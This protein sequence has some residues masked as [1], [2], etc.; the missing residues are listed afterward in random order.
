ME[1]SGRTHVA[2]YADANARVYP[3][4]LAEMQ[5]SLRNF[6]IRLLSD[7]E[8]EKDHIK[9]LESLD[10]DDDFLFLMNSQEEWMEYIFM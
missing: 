8:G 2:N 10:E 6:P 9:F 5:E 3:V 7:E 4:T 1:P